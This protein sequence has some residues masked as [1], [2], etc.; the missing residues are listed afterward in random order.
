MESENVELEEI[1]EEPKKTSSME[2]YKLK[3]LW[4]L[5]LFPIAIAFWVLSK[6]SP[7]IAEYIFARGYYCLLGNIFSYISG[8]FPVSIAEILIVAG[9]IIFFI[10][11]IVWIVRMID[12]KDQNA[13]LIFYK[14]IINF[15][16]AV[17]IIMFFVITFAMVNINRYSFA[18]QA[19]LEIK[20]HSE[21]QLYA[22]TLDLTKK[23]NKL[24]EKTVSNKKGEFELNMDFVKM[25]EE[26]E[27]AYKR[28]G[29]EYKVLN[30]VHINAKPVHFSRA[31]SFSG[32]IGVY[33]PFTIEANIDTDICEY[34]QPAT[35][36]HEIAHLQGYMKEDEAN[37][38]AFLVCRKSKNYAFQYSGYMSALSL[39]LNSL[40]DENKKLYDRIY[41][42]ISDGV[43]ADLQ[44]NNKY[45]KRI[46]DSQMAQTIEK[47]T[48]NF[49]DT[50]LK[51]S[52]QKGVKSYGLAVDL[53]LAERDKKTANK[54]RD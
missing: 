8:F 4:I 24:K 7:W 52:G 49:N 37:Y 16:D 48:T 10:A 22:L 39:C 29:K 5:L 43:K 41:A 50:Y 3:R 28:A 14:G 27:K 25:R 44:A 11:I 47:T 38:I 23:C 51:I 32:I 9:T 26:A 18:K 40:G 54:K 42:N 13:F 2:K 15:L 53:L 20:E 19:D 12:H 6:I 46:Y 21:K 1:K 17:A 36:C 45:W 31:M 34:K 33:T 35:M 30:K